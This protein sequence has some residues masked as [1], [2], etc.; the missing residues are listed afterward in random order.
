MRVVT[1]CHAA[2]LAEYGHRWLDSRKNWPEGTEFWFYKEGYELPG[3]GM[4]VRDLNDDATLMAWKRKMRH[5]VAPGWQWDVVK[6]AH[7]VFAVYDAFRDYDGIGVWMDADCVTYK[8][9]PAGLIERQVA[10]AY[11]ACYQ[12][13]GMYTETGFWVMD[14]SHPSHKAFMDSWRDWYL[15]EQFKALPQWHDCMTL[16]YNIRRFQKAGELPI[17]SLSGEHAKSMHP[18]ALS[19][20]G[21]YIDHCKGPRKELGVSAENRHRRS[22]RAVRAS[23]GSGSED[24]ASRNTRNRDVERLASL[25]DAAGQSEEQVLRVRPVRGRHPGD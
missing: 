17:K 18:Q 2:G 21:Q 11:L 19:A 7:K 25:G 9:I 3:E 23:R 8:P 10:G 6:F 1:T 15:G 14:C 20:L 12:R 24:A 13:V 4:V 22:G 16:D 5:Y